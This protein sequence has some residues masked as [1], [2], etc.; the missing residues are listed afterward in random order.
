[1]WGKGFQDLE[2]MENINLDEAEFIDMGPLSRDSGFNVVAHRVK[3]GIMV[4]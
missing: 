1:M 3:E 4:D 2:I